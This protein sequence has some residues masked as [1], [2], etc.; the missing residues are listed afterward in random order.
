ME[1]AISYWE[2]YKAKGDD[3]MILKCIDS[4][5]KGNAY[6]L[7]AEEEILLL[8]A[9]CRLMDVK[10]AIGF[11]IGK[12]VGCLVTHSHKDHI[13]YAKISLLQ[14][15]RFI[16]M[17]RQNNWLIPCMESGYTVSQK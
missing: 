8:E 9:G 14:E 10:K 6:A 17:T 4:G 13:G 15:S 12:V 7:I 2:T 16:P 5:S 11:Q 3:K 1:P